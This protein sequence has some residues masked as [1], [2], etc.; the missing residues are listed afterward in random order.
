MPKFSKLFLLFSG[1]CVGQVAH[2]QMGVGTTSPTEMLDVVGTARLR[3]I[4]SSG[5]TVM[6]T[7]DNTGV[8]RQQALPTA[9]APTITGV[10]G[11]GVSLSASNWVNYNYTSAYI[12]IPANSKYIVQAFM[13]LA[14]SVVPSGT[15]SVWVRSSFSDSPTT[16]AA[17][18]DIVGSVYISGLLSPTSTYSM[19]NGAI[20]LNNTSGSAKRYYYWAGNVIANG[21]Y[22]GTI[23]GFAGSWS[24]NQL[25]AIPIK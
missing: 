25:F 9:S 2:A 1:L 24:E 20:I 4:P 12:E 21:G 13:L 10:R 7:A 8:I 15:Q 5:G 22:T 23:N 3:T 6:L 14:G 11:G 17:S 19:L 18:S 16:F